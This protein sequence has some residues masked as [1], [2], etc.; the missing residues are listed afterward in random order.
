MQ[1]FFN[2]LVVVL[3]IW[4]QL[5]SDALFHPTVKIQY[6]KKTFAVGFVTI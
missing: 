5:G 2:I 3:E 6:K 4:M 1:K